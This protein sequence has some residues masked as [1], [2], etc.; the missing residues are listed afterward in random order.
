LSE[1][2]KENEKPEE[3]SLFRQLFTVGSVGIQF[4]LS[5]FVGFYIGYYLDKFLKTFPWFTIVFLI[6]GI[7]AAFTELF[8]LAKREDRND[9]KDS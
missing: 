1:K 7:I 8:R 5:I 2:P 4:A 9:K 6:L 3:K